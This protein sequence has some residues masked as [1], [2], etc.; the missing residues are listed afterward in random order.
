MAKFV[1]IVDLWKAFGSLEVLK[2]ISFGVE[3][4]ECIAISGASGSGKTTLLQLIGLLDRP[5]SGEIIVNGTSIVSLPERKKD[6][7]RSRRLGFVFQFHELLPEFTA[8][9][10]VALPALIGGMP[11]KKALKE[12]RDLLIALNLQER[13]THRPHQLSGGENQRV[14]VARALINKPDL[15]L[16][17]EPSGSLDRAT[18]E[19]LHRLLDYVKVEWGQTM[20]IAT[21]DHELATRADRVLHLENGCM[22]SSPKSIFLAKKQ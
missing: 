13:A 9:E 4:G 15:L 11:L 12:A 18:K 19:E 8:E 6:T 21:H 1:E 14:A 7:F 17:D 3:K 16:A 5:D 2:G 22:T 20:I 10:N